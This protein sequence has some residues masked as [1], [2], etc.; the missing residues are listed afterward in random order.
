MRGGSPAYG[1]R[2]RTPVFLS[3]LLTLSAC[4]GSVLVE[5]NGQGGGATTAPLCSPGA[6]APCPCPLGSS[7]AAI[8]LPDGSGYGDCACTIDVACTPGSQQS[9]YDGPAATA[10]VGPCMA[11]QRACLSDGSGFGPCLGQV[12]PALDLC[13]TPEDE[14]CNGSQASCVKAYCHVFDPASATTVSDPEVDAAG[15]TYLALFANGLALGGQT[16]A[17]ATLIQYGPS[18][19]LLWAKNIPGH[20][21]SWTRVLANADGGVRVFGEYHGS[22]ELGGYALACGAGTCSYAADLASNGDVLWAADLPESHSVTGSGD[23]LVV[24]GHGEPCSTQPYVT[25]HLTGMSKG[26][27][28][29]WTLP[30]LVGGSFGGTLAPAADGRTLY[31]TP[32]H[33]TIDVGGDLLDAGPGSHMLVLLLDSGGVP[34]V[35]RVITNA[36][37]EGRT[38]PDGDIVVAGF[39][40]GPT[41]LGAGPLP[42]PTLA[43]TFVARYDGLGNLRWSRSFAETTGQRIPAGRAAPQGDTVVTGRFDA[44][45]DLSEGGS[46]TPVGGEDFF[47]ARFDAN[48]TIVAARQY[49]DAEDQRSRGLAL[50]GSGTPVIRGAFRGSFDLGWGPVHALAG[51]AESTFLCQL[52]E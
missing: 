24:A 20:E 16:Y 3:A 42:T 19:D 26:G 17:G 1:H 32:F 39:Y 9:C 6:E 27:A 8:C 5:T 45:M 28:C 35:T 12:L 52:M 37:V 30:L 46:F 25:L 23:V 4:G 11:G 7:G 18:G 49:G 51:P 21:T 29:L 50:N 36:W 47:V 13:I 2:M 22:A 10:G 38:T 31:T 40:A 44:P 14:D 15:N 43:N 33:E 34:L 41:D 48:G